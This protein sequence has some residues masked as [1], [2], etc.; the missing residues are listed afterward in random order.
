MFDSLR[1]V[2]RLQQTSAILVV[3]IIAVVG[4]LLLV[5][6]HAATPYASITADKGTTTNGA[7]SQACAG[8]SSGNCVVFGGSQAGTKHY[9]YVFTDGY[10]DVYDMDNNFASVDHFLTPTTTAGVRGESASA[11]TGMLYISYGGWGGGLNGSMLEYNL[12]TKSTVYTKNY[13]FGIDSMDISADGKTIYMPT[14]ENDTGNTWEVIDALSGNVIGAMHGGAGPH[15]TVVGPSGH[16]YLGSRGNA[17][18]SGTDY[19]YVANGSSPYQLLS[20]NIG[21]L[22]QNVR[23][24]V[25]NKA[26]TLAFTTASGFLGFQVSSITSGKVLYT[27]PVPGFSSSSSWTTPSHGIAISPDEKE[28]WVVDAANNY[29]HVFDISGLPSTAPTKI[30]DVKLQGSL[31]GNESPCNPVWCGKI[32]WVNMSHDGRFVFVGDTSGVI[33]RSTRQIVATVPAL[34][35]SRQNIEIDWQNGKV[36]YAGSRESNGF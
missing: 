8:A 21:Q 25:I 6:S 2:N 7:T 19:L 14:G 11:A 1:N 34:G 30:A 28:A 22:K 32:G 3:L 16:V 36:V 4:T 17:G 13:P 15:N 24:F 12:L 20:P 35:N 33:D 5:G 26:E 9:E 29:V 23:P 10:V 18:G 31:S 27:V